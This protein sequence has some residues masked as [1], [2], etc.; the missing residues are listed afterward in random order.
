VSAATALSAQVPTKAPTPST[1]ADDQRIRAITEEQVAAWNI[2]D[3]KA[4][5]ARFAE[6]GSF[7]NIRGSVFYGHQAFEDRHVEIFATFFKGSKLAMTV[8]RILTSVPT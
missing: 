7:T 2:G 1:I 6:D 4:F 8:N 5:S 3:G